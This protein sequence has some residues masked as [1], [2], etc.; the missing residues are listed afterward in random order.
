MVEPLEWDKI[1]QAKG[2]VERES[3]GTGE[4]ELVLLEIIFGR[5]ETLLLVLI[6]DLGTEDVEPRAGAGVVGGGGLV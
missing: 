2:L 5:D 6:V 4:S 1:G 3:D